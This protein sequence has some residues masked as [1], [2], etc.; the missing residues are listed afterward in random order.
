M[1]AEFPNTGVPV[2]VVAEKASQSLSTWI[3]E[4]ELR[5]MTYEALADVDAGRF[6][7]HQTVQT[8]VSGLSIDIRNCGPYNGVLPSR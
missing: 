2:M 3:D 4:E 1:A 6:I 7:E 8:W 5:Q